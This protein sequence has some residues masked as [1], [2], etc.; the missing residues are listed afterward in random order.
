MSK[1]G[2]A[3]DEASLAGEVLPGT[4]KPLQDQLADR[5][6]CGELERIRPDADFLR[7]TRLDRQQWSE[8]LTWMRTL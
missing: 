8:L 4:G 1:T 5:S 7:T 3:G 2:T 6:R